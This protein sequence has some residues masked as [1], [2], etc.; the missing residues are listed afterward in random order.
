MPRHKR[1]YGLFRVCYKTLPS[2]I[3]RKFYLREHADMAYTKET[4][5]RVFQGALLGGFFEG[6]PRE[7]RPVA[8]G[9]FGQGR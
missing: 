3:Q 8:H 4:A 5:V 1:L 7:L 6:K 2:G 9:Y